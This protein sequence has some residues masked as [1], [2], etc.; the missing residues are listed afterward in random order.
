MT[1]LSIGLVVLLALLVVVPHVIDLGLKPLMHDESLFGFYSYD[2][3]KTGHYTHIPMLHGPVLM[4]TTGTLF[5]VFGDSIVVGRALVAC[6]WMIGL[7]AA[8]GLVPR[9]VRWWVAPLLI[10]STPLLYYSRFFRDDMMFNGVLMLAMLCVVLGLSRHRLRYGTALLGSFLLLFLLAIMENSLFVYASGVTFGL[11]WLAARLFVHQPISC[12]RARPASWLG[13]EPFSVNTADQEEAAGQSGRRRRRGDRQKKKNAATAEN[14]V[15]YWSSDDSVPQAAEAAALPPPLPPA[16]RTPWWDWVRRA[17]LEWAIGALLGLGLVL[18]FYGITSAPGKFAPFK[19]LKDTWDYWKGQHE[20]HRIEGPIHYYLPILLT[21]ELPLLLAIGAG[22]VW[23][24]SLRRAR[25]AVYGGGMV[26]WLFIWAVWRTICYKDFW[27][28]D[29]LRNPLLLD[30]PHGMQAVMK[31]LHIEPNLSMLILGLLI[32][33]LLAWSIL[34]LLEHRLLAAWMGWWAAC[35]LFQYSSAGEKVPWLVVHIIL[36]LYMM[37]GWLWA[38]RL[39][40]LGWRAHALVTVLV[41]LVTLMALRNDCYII[42]SR[43]ADPRERLVYNHTTLEFDKLSRSMFGLWELNASPMIGQRELSSSP[44]PLAQRRVALVDAPGWPGVWYYRHCVYLL[45]GGV[46]QQPPAQVDL[47][48]GD[49]SSLEPLLA[50]VN[51][52]DWIVQ[53]MSLRNAWLA[54][55]PE[56]D[57]TKWGE[58]NTWSRSIHAW[59]R[60][61]W[62]RETWTTVG[63][64]PIIAMEP[65][66]MRR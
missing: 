6:A 64:F 37:L 59:W 4:L 34:A 40:R 46:Q 56:E 30:L 62:L 1:P 15:D 47:I 10:T 31:F 65:V 2:F 63:G 50:K 41:V 14:G 42:G 7:I 26:L 35:S 20:M 21:Y 66:K 8:L 33:P 43:A 38:P 44:I 28:F 17:H 60:Y 9:R 57:M 5:K 12:L 61:Y 54:P 36:P 32:V 29:Q 25:A 19:N 13:D 24:A 18:W 49:Q 55:W 52:D 16:R 45:M 23:D 48:I 58:L 22:L 3:F 51:K 53:N 39:R 11:V 27:Q